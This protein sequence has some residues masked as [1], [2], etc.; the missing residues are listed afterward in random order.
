MRVSATA[1]LLACL[2]LCVIFAIILHSR[3]CTPSIENSLPEPCQ[4]DAPHRRFALVLP[5]IEKDVLIL[6]DS[7]RSWTRP[8]ARRNDLLDVIFYFNRDISSSA[9][10]QQ[11]YNE[12]GAA[13]EV[14]IGSCIRKHIFL[15]ANLTAQEDGYPHGASLQWYKLMLMDTATFPGDYEYI[16][17][18]EHD[19]KPLRPHWL[20]ALTHV[21]DSSEDFYM[22]GS[23][24]R[25]HSALK[26]HLQQ[27]NLLNPWI[28]HINGN[29]FYRVGD[30][31]WRSI[32]NR[33]LQWSPPSENN[34]SPWD[35]S[36]WVFMHDYRH[37]SEFQHYAHKI[38]YTDVLQNLGDD[39][40]PAE[41]DR[42][43]RECAATYF[44]HGNSMSAGRR[45]VFPVSKELN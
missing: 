39:A 38:Q 25:G 40:S 17:W 42:I 32:I 31:Y 30:S 14:S 37:F 19:V 15:S 27:G 2:L 12:L 41:E 24:F 20:D 44:I 34:W 8:C 7:I 33:T 1:L 16:F 26:K 22:K 3:N 5:F 28:P 45:I 21:I 43:R 13:I 11:I 6:R 9:R 35:V 4:C 23:I 29:A 10:K 36:L 18:M